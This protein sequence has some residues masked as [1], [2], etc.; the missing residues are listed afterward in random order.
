MLQA[1]FDPTINTP[2]PVQFPGRSLSIL[3][4]RNLVQLGATSAT[5]RGAMPA[6]I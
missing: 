6:H 3:T 4:I 1:D 2:F 5:N